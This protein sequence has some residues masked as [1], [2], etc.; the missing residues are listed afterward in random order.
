[1]TEWNAPEYAKL[2][3]LQAAMA[4]EVLNLLRPRLRGDERILDVGCG[5]GKVTREIAAMVPKGQRRRSRCFRNDGEI[6]TRGRPERPCLCGAH[7]C[8]F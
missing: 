1:M 8:H 4:S 6:C 5:N 3:S 7:E 2:S